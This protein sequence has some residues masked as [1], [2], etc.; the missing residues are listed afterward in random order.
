MPKPALPGTS[1]GFPGKL[2][3]TRDLY[4]RPPVFVCK[5]VP[6]PSAPD[7]VHWLN[8]TPGSLH[9]RPIVGGRDQQPRPQRHPRVARPRAPSTDILRGR[10]WVRSE[11]TV[12]PSAGPSV[13]LHRRQCACTH[14]HCQKTCITA[15]ASTPRLN[16]PRP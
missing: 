4:R 11:T 15:W 6:G 2:T 3:R 16:V 13:V 9:D 1:T 5:D 8:K 14:S 12:K 7:Y 10:H